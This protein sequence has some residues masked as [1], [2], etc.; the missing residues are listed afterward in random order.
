MFNCGYEYRSTDQVISIYNSLGGKRQALDPIDSKR[1]S[2]VLS[3]YVC[4]LTPQDR[5][6]L[7][8][9]LMAMRFD[10]VRRYLSYRR[11]DVK[12]VQN[13][14]DIDD[15][16]IAKVLSQ[17]V[18][19]MQMT[20]Q[21]TDEFY[22]CASKLHV[23]PVDE[24]TRVSDFIPEI[25]AFIEELIA[26]DFA[27]ATKDGNV[28]FKVEKKEDYGKLSNQNISKLH[29]SVRKEIEKDKESPLDFA[30]W[31]R[32]ESTALSRP[33]PWGVGRPGWH[34]E[35][36]VMA[37]ET[38][39]AAIDIH[40]GALD[41]KF[42]HHENEIAQSEAHS[43]GNFASVWMHCGLLN[44]EGQKMS[45]SL[46]NFVTV[47][48]S[49]ERY[50]VT[51]IRYAVAR[52]HYRSHL[53]LTNKLIRESL[54]ALLDFHKLFDS[55]PTPELVASSVTEL[56]DEAQ[57]LARKFE[58]AMDNDFN[59]PEAL[60][61]LDQARSKLVASLG[62]GCSTEDKHVREVVYTIKALGN[63]L[64]LFFDSLETVQREGLR[65]MASMLGS[66]VLTPSDVQEMLNERREARTQKDFARSDAIRDSLKAKGIEVLDSSEGSSWRFVG[67]MS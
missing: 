45:K 17:N 43:G 50:G 66:E 44:I 36:S 32:D 8:H 29:E 51:P 10:M 59:S 41:L 2:P 7:G 63:I 25:I 56:G 28:Y 19:P 65:A 46:N 9:A 31:K 67:A 37:H 58:L 13:V 40:G 26:R 33:S 57:A 16:I 35:C 15:K 5:A 18:D 55:L 27:Y 52:H 53:D 48:E 20:R 34:I 23:L 42:P 4:G 6:H 64:G 62:K 11:L 22:E 38:L 1:E 47:V 24:L 60:V 12:F 49:L 21:Y 14:T 54:N 39:G 61:V 30:L 3:M